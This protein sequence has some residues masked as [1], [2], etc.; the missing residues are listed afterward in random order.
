MLKVQ[1]LRLKY[2]T[3]EG[4]VE[5]VRG[6]SLNVERGQFYTLLGPSGCG[7]TTTLRCVAGLETPTSGRI[8]FGERDVTQLPPEKRNIGM[9]FQNYALFPHMT[10]AE[11][12]GFGLD[13]RGI[14]ETDARSKVDAVMEMVQLGGF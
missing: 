9:V 5:A 14:R 4:E 13:M 11:N 3:D 6:L 12:I 10:V 2:R 8:L 7:K 1:D